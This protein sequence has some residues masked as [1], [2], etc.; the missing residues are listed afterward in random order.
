MA[1]SY[2][3]LL[4][5][6]P[7]NK[8][9]DVRLAH[10]WFAMGNIAA[11]QNVAFNSLFALNGY[12]PTMLQMLVRI[13]LMRGNY[14]VAL[15]YITLLEKTVHYAGWATAQRRFLFDDEAVEQDPSLGTGRAS[16]PLDDSF[17]LLASPMD[18]LYKIVAV[19]PAN[20]NAMQY[21]LAYLLLA[22]D[23]SLIHIFY[24]Y[25]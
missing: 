2:T 10:L 4:V 22:K 12:N 23:L 17:V 20:S 7:N 8:S 21:A 13:E 14:L 5:Y 9:A 15:K 19:N 6:I 3:H 25:A 16:F 1:V 11:A 18:D 24:I